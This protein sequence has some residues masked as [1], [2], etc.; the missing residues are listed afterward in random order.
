[1]NVN[2]DVGQFFGVLAETNYG[3]NDG[4]IAP[5]SNINSLIG[6]LFINS[7]RA[8][9]GTIS[10]LVGVRASN[11][12]TGSGDLTGMTISNVEGLSV[13]STN[14]S[15]K[16]ATVGTQS[17]ARLFNEGGT[18]TGNSYGLNIDGVSTT[19]A[20]NYGVYIGEVQNATT[21][22]YALYSN[23]TANSYFRGNVAVGTTNASAKLNVGNG[24]GCICFIKSLYCARFC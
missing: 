3:S 24:E 10:T 9:T 17:M 21:A 4:T 22:N 1:M 11:L 23:A 20:E 8:G 12:S 15:A 2:K 18:V 7:L 16:G 19:A 13:Q 5:T 6:G 14:Y